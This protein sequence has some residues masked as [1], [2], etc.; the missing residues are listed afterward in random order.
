MIGM[1][2]RIFSNAE[3]KRHLDENRSP[4][5]LY[6]ILHRETSAY[7]NSLSDIDNSE[8]NSGENLQ[9]V[10]SSDLDLII[11]LDRLYNAL[12]EKPN[13]GIEQKIEELKRLIDNRSRPYY[14]RMKRKNHNPFSIVEKSSCSDATCRYRPYISGRSGTAGNSG[15]HPLRQVPHHRLEPC[16]LRAIQNARPGGPPLNH[17]GAP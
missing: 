1:M 10:P 8:Y 13:A 3:K 6:S 7:F 17:P 5:K 2:A 11:R 12:R 9:G 14:E 16:P 4:A 15:M